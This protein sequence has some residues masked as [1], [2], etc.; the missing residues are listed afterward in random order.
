MISK[1][2]CF[3]V[4]V[5]WFLSYLKIYNAFWVYSCIWY[6][7]VIQFHFFEC[8]CLVFPTPLLK[9]LSIPH[10]YLLYHTRVPY[11][12]CLWLSTSTFTPYPI[13]T[14]V[15]FPAGHF[16][17]PSC[18]FNS[19]RQFYIPRLTHSPIFIPPT[20][21][22]TFFTPPVSRP[23]SSQ[24]SP[25]LILTLDTLVPHRRVVGPKKEASF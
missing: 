25:S 10:S 19:C 3:L 8:I 4:G 17:F 15:N 6:K 13:P 12:I 23:T 21:T 16:S 24:F 5:L 11:S 7:K 22:P 20:T 9:I 2:L 18:F 1:S 14:H